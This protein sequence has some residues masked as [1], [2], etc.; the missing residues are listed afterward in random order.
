MSGR[1]IGRAPY[2]GEGAAFPG[3]GF[4][5][6]WTLVDDNRPQQLLTGTITCTL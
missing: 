3:Q 2:L 4:V 6:H 1:E 5:Q